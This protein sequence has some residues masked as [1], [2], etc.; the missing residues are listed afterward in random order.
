MSSPTVE[1]TFDY[2]FIIVGSGFGG[3]V[4][5]L[6]LV[7]KGYRVLML[8]KGSEL[9][10]ADFPRTNWNLKRWMWVPWVGFRGLFKMTFFRHVTVLSGVGV[11][12]GSL[13]YAC[14][15]PVPSDSFFTAS[16]WAHLADW[17]QELQPFYTE[18][19]RM[20]GVTPVPFETTPD[21]VISRI[22]QKRGQPQAH[23]P[24]E[25]AV[26][27]GEPGKT[28]PDPFFGGRGPERTGCIRCGGCMLGCPHNAK[29]SLDKNYLH[30]ARQLGMQLHADTEVT[31]LRPLPGGGYR[32]EAMHGSRHGMRAEV[33]Y[34]AGQVVLSGGVLGTVDLLL[35]MKADPQ[36]L[37]NLSD[38]V[39]SKVR[40]NNEA[41]FGVIA[42]DI[43]EDLSKGVA[44]G[45]I[46][47][48]DEHSHLEPVRY[49]SGSGFF[50]LLMSPHVGGPNAIVRL[51]RLM[52][53]LFRHP[54]KIL[55]ALLVPDL[56]KK[57][58]ILL[59]MRTLEGTIRLERAWHGGL[60]TTTEDGPAPQASMPEATELAHAYADEVGGTPFSMATETLFN[61]PTTAHILGG[62]AM[63]TSK[64]TGV[65]DADHR[66]HGYEGLYVMDGSAMSANPGVNPS[67]TITAMA[68][69]ACSKIPA[70]DAVARTDPQALSA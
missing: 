19:K 26:Y 36:G 50:R 21:R 52:T 49:N 22:A 64:E 18:A 29:N 12:G 48:T 45:S 70:K 53:I 31:A 47:E 27:F 7:E 20:L 23:H 60:T 13:T 57:T 41:L 2:D 51:F 10:A 59:Y 42:P 46:Y 3:S 69:R 44:I 16:S 11:G 66:V 54:I 56:S 67:L 43:E 62:C 38:Q 68:E 1:R 15:H 35:S 25:V 63:G 17:K 39:G 40:T 37:P 6:R 32:V 30:L 65:I 14:T 55:K 24:T 61:I 34:T 33:A 58:T 8:E 28:V 9:T 5:G 4:A